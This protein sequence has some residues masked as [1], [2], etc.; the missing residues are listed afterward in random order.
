MNPLHLT[1]DIFWR[2]ALVTGAVDVVWVLALTRLVK[3]SRFH[4][5]RWV[6]ALSAALFWS[7]LGL[8]LVELFWQGFYEHFQ[9]DWMRAGGILLV[10]VPMGLSLALL[11]HWLAE[12]LP[13]HPMLTFCLLGGLQGLIEHLWGV[14]GLKI[15][16][17]PIL[18]GVEPLSVLAFALPEY[19]LY[20]SCVASLALVVMLLA[21]TATRVKQFLRW[22]R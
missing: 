18:Q 8:V 4:Q 6:L 11:F 14:Y 10:T 22:R 12:R 7:A 1:S 3:R 21:Q 17:I 16:S 20:W 15:M 19:M 13:G 2:S 9:P 5:L